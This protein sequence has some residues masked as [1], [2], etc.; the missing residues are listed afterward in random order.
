MFPRNFPSTGG[1]LRKENGLKVPVEQN[2]NRKTV[3]SLEDRKVERMMRAKGG[4]T[5]YAR[6]CKEWKRGEDD[7]K[8]RETG[9][10]GNEWIVQM[11]RK[12]R[13]RVRERERGIITRKGGHLLTVA[14]GKGCLE[15]ETD[16]RPS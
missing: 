14:G 8:D 13:R 11:S 12:E 5:S 10:S 15:L 1:G 9:D 16:R 6:V 2:N 3:S 4:D 7:R